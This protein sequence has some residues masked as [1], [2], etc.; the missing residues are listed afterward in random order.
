MI[1]PLNQTIETDAIQPL[2]TSTVFNET[3]TT[4]KKK[5]SLRRTLSKVF[6]FRKDTRQGNSSSNQ[7]NEEDDNDDDNGNISRF[8]NKDPMPFF[9]I[10]SLRLD[11][12]I[13]NC[14]LIRPP[15]PN[16]NHVVERPAYEKI[17]YKYNNLGIASTQFEGFEKLKP[18]HFQMSLTWNVWQN[19]LKT[20]N[21]NGSEMIES[22]YKV[23]DKV[24]NLK[25]INDTVNRFEYILQPTDLNNGQL[26]FFKYGINPQ[27]KKDPLLSKSGKL[28]IRIPY[29]KLKLAW[30]SLIPIVLKDDLMWCN[31]DN[32]IVGIS[33]AKAAKEKDNSY[34]SLWLSK[35]GYDETSINNLLNEV[36]LRSPTELKPLFKYTKYYTNLD[37]VYHTLD[38][39]DNP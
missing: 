16:Y 24:W 22:R 19:I 5:R 18:T 2:D 13:D 8:D 15:S 6:S 35:T 27:R 31:L 30:E 21:Y 39:I 17:F 14:K 9:T 25:Q 1:L 4:F 32:T 34:V 23:I 20:I 38:N 12:S 33:W 11:K 10:K 28:T 26:M 3:S 29:N 37:D 7:S 36:M